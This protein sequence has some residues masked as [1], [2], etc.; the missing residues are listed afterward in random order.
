MASDREIPG[1]VGAEP[2]EE[3]LGQWWSD[4]QEVAPEQRAKMVSQ[5]GKGP[6]KRRRARRNAPELR[7][8]TVYYKPL[9][10]ETETRPD[11]WQVETDEWIVFPHELE[12]LVDDELRAKGAAIYEAVSA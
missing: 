8:A 4:Y 11:Y 7:V 2:R 3:G 1:Q 12:G 5:L 9:R 6:G 10:N